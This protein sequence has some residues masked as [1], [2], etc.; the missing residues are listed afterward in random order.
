MAPAQTV[1]EFRVA[2]RS[3][4]KL[5]GAGKPLTVVEESIIASKIVALRE[6]FLNWKNRRTRMPS[7]S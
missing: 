3:L 4:L 6:E 2:T 7:S 1:E 5:L